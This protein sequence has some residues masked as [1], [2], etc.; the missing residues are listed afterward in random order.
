MPRVAVTRS[1]SR[2]IRG[3]IAS[4]QT[5]SPDSADVA[6]HR[7]LP[8]YVGWVATIGITPKGDIVEWSDDGLRPAESRWVISALVQGSKQYPALASLIPPRPTT[9]HTCPDCQGTGRLRIPGL[10]ESVL[11]NVICS[12]GGVGWIDS[13][14]PERRSIL[15]RLRDW[16]S[17]LPPRDGPERA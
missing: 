6:R 12:C 11:D 17:R 16:L 15:S 13:P 3:L 5:D 1:Q 7:A 14:A 10:A 4:F 8:L 9:A 2:A